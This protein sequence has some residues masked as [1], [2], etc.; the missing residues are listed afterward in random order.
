MCFACKAGAWQGTIYVQRVRDPSRRLATLRARTVVQLMAAPV[1]V[2]RHT[3]MGKRA[4]RGPARES[5]RPVA[6][7]GSPSSR[8]G[9][10]MSRRSGERQKDM[11]GAGCSSKFARGSSAALSGRS[12]SG[13]LMSRHSACSSNALPEASTQ[14]AAADVPKTQHSHTGFG[15]HRDHA[16][17]CV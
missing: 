1:M 14:P 7:M 2:P 9:I 17:G 6:G 12:S 15:P 5:R 4:S 10:R 13:R 3:A 11:M 16:K 8:L